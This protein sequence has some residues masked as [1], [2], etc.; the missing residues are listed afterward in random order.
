LIHLVCFLT[1]AVPSMSKQ[2]TVAQA[3]TEAAHLRQQA[4][5]VREQARQRV[6]AALLG[7]PLT[8]R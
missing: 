6:E 3:R 1:V 2:S 8:V 7:Q 5:Q 4:A